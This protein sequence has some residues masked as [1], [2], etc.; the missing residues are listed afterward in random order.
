MVP[1][2][3]IYWAKEETE[4]QLGSK[5]PQVCTDGQGLS[6]CFLEQ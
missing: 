1:T 3:Q 6:S 2:V 4:T 5:T